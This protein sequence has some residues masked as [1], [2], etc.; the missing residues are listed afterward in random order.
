MRPNGFAD[1]WHYHLIDIENVI[2]G[3]IRGHHAFAGSDTP[4]LPPYK[5]DELS[6]TVGVDPEQFT[7]HTAM[8]DVLWVRAQWDHVM[9]VTA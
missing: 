4:I 6:E 1:P 5:S 2:V 8:G 7:R 3:W 9:G